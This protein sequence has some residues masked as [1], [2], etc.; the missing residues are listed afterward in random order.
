MAETNKILNYSF[1]ERGRIYT[2]TPGESK[3]IDIPAEQIIATWD[4]LDRDDSPL[5]VYLS[6]KL[7]GEEKIKHCLPVLCGVTSSSLSGRE[8]T[9]PI[10]VG[11]EF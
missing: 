5:M 9:P 11:V 1:P 2:I 4:F 8:I 6:C 7:V 3:F 10:F